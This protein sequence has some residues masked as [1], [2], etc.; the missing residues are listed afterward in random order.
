[1]DT[2]HS[3]Q[4]L[5]GLFAGANRSPMARIPKPA[6]KGSRPRGIVAWMRMFFLGRTVEPKYSMGLPYMPP[7]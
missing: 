3:L 1:M 4:H 5:N 2:P 7:H 6:N